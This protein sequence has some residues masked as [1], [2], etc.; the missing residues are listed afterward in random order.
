MPTRARP[1]RRREGEGDIHSFFCLMTFSLQLLFYT[2]LFSL[3]F[4][5][6]RLEFLALEALARVVGLAR[7]E[8]VLA[9]QVHLGV[10]GLDDG[11]DFGVNLL[12]ALRVLAT[13]KVG[14][15]V[16]VHGDGGCVALLG[17]LQTQAKMAGGTRSMEGEVGVVWTKQ[18][19]WERR[20]A[21]GKGVFERGMG[22]LGESKEGGKVAP[23]QRVI[24]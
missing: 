18:G 15:H 8:L 20:G 9:V 13:R 3:F 24:L 11:A 16:E 4:C 21:R 12:G 1:R 6:A 19:R 14:R 23:R 5:A 10:V 7:L 2:A 22:E 17:H